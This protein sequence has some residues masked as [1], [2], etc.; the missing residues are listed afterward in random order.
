MRQRR[1][2]LRAGE[3]KSSGKHESFCKVLVQ[4][5][6]NNHTGAGPEKK[7]S[8]AMMELMMDSFYF[9]F[10]K[11][12]KNK[13]I[14]KRLACMSNSSDGEGSP[15]RRRSNNGQGNTPAASAANVGRGE[16]QLPICAKILRR[17]CTKQ[18]S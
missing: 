5:D 16:R 10:Q 9:F 3:A 8:D 17:H 15:L 1:R 14:K 2:E 13:K 11:P 7:K 18:R 12:K 6:V 4:F